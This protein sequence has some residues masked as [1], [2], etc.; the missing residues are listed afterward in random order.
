MKP[1]FTEIFKHSDVLN[2]ISTNTLLLAG[3]LARFESKKVILDLGCGKGLPSLLWASTFGVEVE[4]FDINRNFVRY[5]NSRAKLLNLSHRVKCSYMD[6]R[7]LKPEREYD[8]VVFLGL[9]MKHV[10]GSIN[11]ALKVFRT[12]LR[13]NGILISAEPVWLQKPVPSSAL[14]ALG[15]A[16]DNFLEETEMHQLMEKSRFRVL[17][18][19]V[20]SKGDWELYVLPIYTNM[21]SIIENNGKF[22]SEA[23]KVMKGFRA[24]YDAVGVHWNMVLWVAESF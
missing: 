11:G 15:E 14:R 21:R 22:A 10:Y 13:K 1:S 8:A 23:R 24:E 17:G 9:G 3:K 19:F 20:S 12:M 18:N 6:V 7:K 16:E 5:A 2:P 4:G